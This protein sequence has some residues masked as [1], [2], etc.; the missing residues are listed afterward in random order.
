[1]I[2]HLL[3]RKKRDDHFLFITIL[4]KPEEIQKKFKLHKPL[5]DFIA[6]YLKK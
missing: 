5:F 4:K 1:M 6:S 3:C 2:R